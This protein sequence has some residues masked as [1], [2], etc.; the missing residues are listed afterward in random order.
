MSE[1][2]SYNI[3]IE[4]LGRKL[5]LDKDQRLHDLL[6]SEGVEFPCGGKGRCGACSIQ[7]LEGM[8][9]PSAVELD[10]FSEDEI[11]AGWRFACRT[12]LTG[13]IRLHLQQWDGADSRNNAILT[14][15]AQNNPLNKQWAI[16]GWQ[17]T[18]GLGIAVDL[19]TTTIV[20]QL[21]DLAN[22][23][24]I[25]VA[26]GINPQAQHGADLMSR[27]QFAREAEGFARLVTLV[28][29]AIGQL[30]GELMHNN[31]V[32]QCNISSDQLQRI[33][34]VGNTAMFHLFAGLDITP[35][36][37]VPF[38]SEHKG[39]QHFS[40]SDLNWSEI[41]GLDKS[42]LKKHS[43][44]VYC[45]PILGGFVG[46]D[47]FAGI[48]ASQM[49]LSDKIIMLVDIGTN[50]EIVIGNR[51]RILCASTAAG[52]A[53]EGGGVKK[54]MVASNG[55]IDAV[56]LI[57]SELTNGRLECHVIGDTDAKGLCGSGL[58]DAVAAALDAGWIEPSGRM[59]TKNKE[60]V[61]TKKVSLTQKD[62]RQLQL[63]KGAITAGIR[64]L[65]TEY[66]IDKSE[67][68]TI[69]LAGAFGNYI[70]IES[71]IRIGL[72]EFDPEKITAAGN[73]ALHGAKIAL[74]QKT[75]SEQNQIIKDLQ[76]KTEHIA[77][78]DSPQFQQQ[79]IEAT[80]FP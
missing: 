38:E 37:S 61:L 69:Y 70:N 55:A 2:K 53:F 67:I 72:L 65:I 41:A 52:P 20:A 8:A 17:A 36:L 10:Y 48:L 21:L 73:T 44:E 25:A 54:G 42:Y 74:G 64:L 13:D 56:E 19:G 66:D 1:K 71:A 22:G 7:L 15:H 6:F 75:L 11:K 14:G 3:T 62:I 80:V 24:V 28:R 33:V 78:G 76:Q 35:L 9:E 32:S 77:L 59:T 79:F 18:Q 27:L 57:K 60:V 47:I 68:A 46:A 39:L 50:G 40:V 5:Q 12:Q 4:P 43:P 51:D 29:N 49:Q 34:V 63:A 30:I 45:L 23:V 58:V 26:K 16:N 31:D